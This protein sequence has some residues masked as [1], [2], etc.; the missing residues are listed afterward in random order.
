[1][2][3]PDGAHKVRFLP[4]R[5]WLRST[6]GK[7]VRGRWDY[8]PP[9]SKLAGGGWFGPGWHCVQRAA[10]SHESSDER[11]GRAACSGQGRGGN[12]PKGKRTILR[13][14]TLLALRRG[15]SVDAK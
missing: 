6:L 14:L 7:E 8:R 5:H 9:G 15:K 4:L 1:V 2:W 3:C 11:E 10:G 13:I 12:R